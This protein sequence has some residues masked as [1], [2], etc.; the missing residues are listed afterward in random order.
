MS[1]QPLRLVIIGA[2]GAA[3][4]HVQGAAS[5]PGEVRIVAAVDHSEKARQ[6]I[7]AESGAGVGFGSTEEFFAG[8]AHGLELDAVV[9]CTPPASRLG[10]VAKAIEHRLSVLS[11]KPLAHT[12]H[13]A[14]L[15]AQIA[16]R[17][18]EFK[19][20]LAF[21]HRFTPAV[22]AIRERIAAGAI[23]RV[24]RFECTIASHVPALRERWLSDPPV[25]GGGCLID[26]GSHAIDLFH[27]LIGPAEVLACV[28][29]HEWHG[30]G[31]SGATLL[32]RSTRPS[33]H[34]VQAG[35]P[36]IIQTGWLEPERA[37]LTVV[38]VEGSLHFDAAH[39]ARVLHTHAEG[40][41]KALEVE[42]TD[43]RFARQ[44]RAFASFVKAGAGDALATFEDGLAVAR[45]VDHAA[46][47]A[48]GR[49]P[50]PA[51]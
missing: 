35:V 48:G 24:T 19:T 50:T 40:T 14:T 23:G 25:S 8:H 5:I 32:L 47:L 44:L 18:P 39:P 36:G 22:R 4:S 16:R 3:S 34:Y 29:D 15:L 27:F 26:C 7:M 49:A 10:L 17:H 9:V 51:A 46:T 33:G 2:G 37:L 38:G 21:S 42:H 43:T 11:E 45:I 1:N 6:K 13:D 41:S 30:R 28:H 20:V 12:M 31:E